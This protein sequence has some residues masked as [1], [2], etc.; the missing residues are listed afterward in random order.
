[1]KAAPLLASMWLAT[2]CMLVFDGDEDDD[3]NDRCAIAAAEPVLLRDP[4]TLMCQAFGST[5]DPGCGPCPATGGAPTATWGVCGSQCET[6]NEGDCQVAPGCRV[7]LDARCAIER[8]CLTNFLGCFPTD[9]SMY[10][11][12]ECW[13][14]DAFQCSRSEGCSALHVQTQCLSPECAQPFALCV[15][16]GKMPGRCWDQVLCDSTG[17]NC[18]SGTTPGISSGCYSGA[19]IPLDI[20]EPPL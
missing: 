17:P 12:I 19:C 2:S 13:G 6:L 14:V 20:C 18:P 7:V 9:G 11:Y 15:P 3:E 10:P 8:N 5:C 1:M 4:A 16:E